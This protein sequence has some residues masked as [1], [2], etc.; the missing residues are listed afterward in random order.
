MIKNLLYSL[1]LHSL[2]FLVVYLNFNLNKVEENKTSEVSVSLIALNGDEKTNNPAAQTA[3]KKEAE[4]KPKDEAKK[5]VEETKKAESPKVSEKNE[6]KKAPKKEA[7]AKAAKAVKK[8]TPPEKSEAVKHPEKEDVKQEDAKKPQEDKVQNQNEDKEK[9]EVVK[10]E[11]D[12]GAKKE[13]TKEVEAA[14]KEETTKAEIS[15]MANS[16]ENL[17]LSGREKFNIQSQL[18]YCYRMALTESKFDGEIQIFAKVH[19]SRNGKITF[20]LEENIDKI[21]YDNSS[22]DLYRKAITNIQRALDLCSPLRNLPLDKYDI[23]KE[24]VLEFGGK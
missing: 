19:I 7:K 1:F 17:D 18:K 23:W 21:R 24:V 14:K 12:L 20:D 5:P 11:K 9:N 2:L 3:T 4:E 6:V 15:D 8:V 13:S 10:K 16:I 22:E